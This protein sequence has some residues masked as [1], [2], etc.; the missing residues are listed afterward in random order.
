MSDTA[1]P[2]CGKPRAKGRIKFCSQEC[3]SV[4]TARRAKAR[5]VARFADA[6][7]SCGKPKDRRVRGAKLCSACKAESLLTQVDRDRER[8]R[9]KPKTDAQLLRSQLYKDGQRRC[10]RCREYLDPDEF[11]T[12]TDR[13]RR[14]S[15]CRA[16]QRAYN[17]ERRLLSHFGISWDDYELLLACQDFRCAICKGKPRKYMLAVDHDHKTGEIRGLLCSRCNHKLLGSANDD[18]QRLRD[19]ADYLEQFA[20][21]DVFGRARF[22]PGFGGAR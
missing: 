19:A 5:A 14:V 18:P 1:C 2:E 4:A 22:V 8:Q 10:A 15:Y 11:T 17:Q 16:C 7:K 12:R 6:C 9:R 3:A 13:N 21:R 20:P